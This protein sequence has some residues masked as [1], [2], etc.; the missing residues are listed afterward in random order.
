MKT[1]QFAKTWR[2]P[3]SE[4][5][6]EEYPAGSNVVVSDDRAEAAFK[7]DALKGEPVD[8]PTDAPAEGKKAAK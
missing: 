5:A 4:T 7:A 3:L 6:Y 1:V 8:A 2:W